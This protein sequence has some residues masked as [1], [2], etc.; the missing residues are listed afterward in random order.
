MR[1][2]LRHPT[3]IPLCYRLGEVIAS[4]SDYLRNIGHGGLCFSSR[5][6]IAPGSCIHIE[7]PIGEPVFEADGVVAWCHATGG[8]FE[9]GVR[10]EGVETDYSVRMVEQ[11]CQIEHY[12]HEILKTEGRALTGEQAAMEW[13]QQ[14]AA[15]FPR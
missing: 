8:D 14:S 1:L 12:R 9:V 10:F 3:D 7:I 15:R 11:V 2:Y 13:I 6:A 5:I 4:R